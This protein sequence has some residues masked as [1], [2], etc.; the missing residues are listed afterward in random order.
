MIR[1][2]VKLFGAFRAH[3][4]SVA[5]VVR[6]HGSISDVRAALLAR[7]GAERAELLSLSR[8]ADSH[9]IL[10]EDTPVADGAALALLPPVSGG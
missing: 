10:A 8:F 5:L 1:V 3:G 9:A 6:K 4:E 7:L 2:N